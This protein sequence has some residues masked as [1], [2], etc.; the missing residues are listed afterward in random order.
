M[1]NRGLLYWASLW[2]VGAA[3]RDGVRAEWDVGLQEVKRLQLHEEGRKSWNSFLG[4]EL[5]TGRTSEQR[6]IMT[7]P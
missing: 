4:A 1:L 2:L 7:F 3:G 6:T 5:G